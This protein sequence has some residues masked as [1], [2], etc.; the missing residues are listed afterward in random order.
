ML[1]LL[2]AIAIHRV[3]IGSSSS[4]DCCRG[5]KLRRGWC[6]WQRGLCGV[7]LGLRRGAGLRLLL[8]LWQLRLLVQP[9]QFQVH[10]GVGRGRGPC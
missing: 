10:L 3:P 7:C 9:Y 6:K 4:S 5:R 1:Q 2:P 8:L